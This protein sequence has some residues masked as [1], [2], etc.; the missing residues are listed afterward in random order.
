VRQSKASLFAILFALL[1]PLAFSAEAFHVVVLKSAEIKPYHDALEGFRST[2]NCDVSELTRDDGQSI[3]A[4]IS[5]MRP[6]A[7]VAIGLDAVR[8]VESVRDIP[9]F[10][11]MVPYSASRGQGQRT[12]SGV[13]MSV[14]FGKQLDAILSIFPNVKR[15]GLVYAAGDLHFSLTEALAAAGSKGLKLIAKQAGKPGQALAL[16]DEMKQGIDVFLM[17]PDRAVVSSEMVNGL[18]LF[19][20]QN[21]VPVFSFSKKYVE[22]GAIAALTVDPFDLGAQTGEVMKK[23]LRGDTGEH[24]VFPARKSVLIINRKVAKKLGVKIPDE[25][26]EKAEIIE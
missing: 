3:P 21:R 7:V 20:F 1:F 5:R 22:M 25:I 2:C 13:Y 19:S 4:A 11:T 26:L 24:A 9:V 14:P 23:T 16:I 6:D 8:Q 10:F 15:V 12:M 17:L 18:L